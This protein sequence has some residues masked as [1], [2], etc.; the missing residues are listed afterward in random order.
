MDHHAHSTN[1]STFNNDWYKPGSALKRLLW[2]AVHEVF[3]DSSFP[4]SSIKVALLKVFG[5]RVGV[6]VVIKPKVRI[7]YPWKLQIGDYSWI[8][9]GVWIDNLDQVT[10][11]KHCCISQG[12]MLLCGNHNYKKSSFDLIIGAITLDDGAWIGA[13]ATVCPGVRCGSHAVLT[14]GS[15]AT[16]N[17]ESHGIYQGNPAVKVKT[18]VIES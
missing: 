9:E 17:L 2:Y 18:R 12:A 1:L 4:V 14:V 8:G 7:K 15:V 10:I 6:G 11:G 5:A 13:Q 16:K 3:L